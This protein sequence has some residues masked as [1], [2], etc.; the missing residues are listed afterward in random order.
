MLGVIG[1]SGLD[2]LKGRSK[3]VVKTRYGDVIVYVNG[4]VCF[5]KRHGENHAYY[6]HEVNYRAIVGALKS[7]GVDRVVAFYTVG[8]MNPKFKPGD[9]VLI[10]D[11]IGL[12]VRY[13]TT[14]EQNVRHVAGFPRFKQWMEYAVEDLRREGV[15]HEDQGVVATTHGPRFETPAEIRALQMLGADFVSMTASRELP[16]F[17]EYGVDVLPLAVVTNWA[18]GVFENQPTEDEVYETASKVEKKVVRVI[19]HLI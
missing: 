13:Q 17:V 2:D 19:N 12:F 3:E 8:S 4:D 10:G 16:L 15:L 6:P 18:A 1:G 5:I 7:V 9:L 14:F 11:H